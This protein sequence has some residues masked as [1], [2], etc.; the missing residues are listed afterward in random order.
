MT[1][2]EVINLS[3]EKQSSAQ[4]L[5]RELRKIPYIKN[6][7]DDEG[8]VDF[9]VLETV[10]DRLRNKNLSVS[11]I[12]SDQ[13]YYEMLLVGTGQ[14]RIKDKNGHCE[15]YRAIGTKAYCRTIYECIAKAVLCLYLFVKE[16]KKE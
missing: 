11:F 15:L 5:Q 10:L 8:N 7:S 6:N 12:M 13:G 9:F 3:C 2:A 14:W 16:N 1:I 4:L